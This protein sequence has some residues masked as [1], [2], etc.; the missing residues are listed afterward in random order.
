[1]MDPSL[2]T[3]QL[4]LHEE[5]GQGG[6]G[7]VYR[8]HHTGLD[9]PVAV[10]V[11][12][13]RHM[14]SKA[15]RMFWREAQIMARLD[16]PNILRVFE[17]R[18][19]Q[20]GPMIV[21]E[22]M[23][24]GSLGGPV[25]D[26]A[27]LRQVALAATSALQALHQAGIVHR[28]VK[29]DNLLE[30]ADGRIKL[31]DMGIAFSPKEATETAQFIGT[32]S[33]TAPELF[34]EP[35]KYHPTTDIFALGVTLYELW[36]GQR[37]FEASTPWALM[38]QINEARREPIESVRPG[39][40]TPTRR[41][42]EEMMDPDPAA[43]PGTSEILQRLLQKVAHTD[44]RTPLVAATVKPPVGPWM[45]TARIY[46]STNW[47]SFAVHHKRTGAQARLSRLN[48]GSSLP[49]GLIL[50]SAQIASVWDHPALVPV[51]DW[52][53]DG[54]R[55]YVVVGSSG[56]PL[57]AVVRRQGVLSEVEALGVLLQ[58]SEALAYLH[59]QGYVY[60]MVE[61]GSVYTR[62]TGQ[63][64]TLSW[65]CF[66]CPIGEPSQGRRMGVMAYIDPA[67]AKSDTFE[68]STDI[69]GLGAVASYALYGEG[70][71]WLVG[72]QDRCQELRQ[73]LPE[74]TAP[75][76][77]LLASVLA[78]NPAHRPQR[79]DQVAAAARRILDRLT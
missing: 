46:R 39:L 37:P 10:K 75:T 21:T 62:A 76:A 57:D 56:Q 34:Q 13:M 2:P 8:G 19:G 15:R 14:D 17:C 26:E 3:D 68:T 36:T 51:M 31:A 42:L 5:I 16:H 29:P 45:P 49:P 23:D 41:L 38:L 44:E 64:A 72:S 28:D 22:W 71:M 43:R 27:R 53:Q 74:L 50:Q 65:P 35:P 40:T 52:G 4:Q 20:Q 73:R 55:P 78:P 18:Q 47:E 24:R 60:Q 1:M 48:P 79:A 7:K 25:K 67:L 11:L 66:C 59:G 33:Y 70:P 77:A 9:I 58:I 30:R 6:F 54:G 32:L 69:Y 63:D 12:H 61:P